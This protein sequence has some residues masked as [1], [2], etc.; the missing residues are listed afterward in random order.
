[1]KATRRIRGLLLVVLTAG[2]RAGETP[3]SPPAAPAEDAIAAV[4]RDYE[5]IKGT[6]SSLERQRLDLPATG[7]SAQAPAA[8]ETAAMSDLTPPL[9]P[10]RS[11]SRPG[12][13]ANWLLDA[14][15]EGEKKSDPLN[16]LRPGM[17][18]GD[19]GQGS[20]LLSSAPDLPGPDQKLASPA[21]PGDA[22]ENPLTAYMSSWMTPR[23]LELLKDKG[24]EAS[25]PVVANPSSAGLRPAA[26]GGLG[27]DPHANPYL[28]DLTPGL[29][30]GPKDLVPAPGPTL[31]LPTPT[32]DLAPLKNQPQPVDQFKLPDD[33]KYFPQLKRF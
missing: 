25:S 7:P 12:K 13:S 15:G 9:S 29:S 6:Q 19:S 27:A 24:A 18:S 2:L 28:V 3:P 17:T 21:K 5:V 10:A 1:M 4:K 33:S 16:G 32:G 30:E 8:G 11:V 20:S 26:G 31:A 23:D 14:M 22:V